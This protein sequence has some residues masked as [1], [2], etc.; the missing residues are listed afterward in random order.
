MV[1]M[2]LLVF[3][4]F[5]NVLR[6]DWAYSEVDDDGMNMLVLAWVAVTVAIFSAAAPQ[7][8]A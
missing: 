6:F 4:L 5:G 8:D 7:G 2:L 3:L 1:L